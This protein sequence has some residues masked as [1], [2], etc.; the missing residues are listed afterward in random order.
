MIQKQA[1][2]L[3][4]FIAHGLDV[5]HVAR[6]RGVAPY[7]RRKEESILDGVS[8]FREFVL[9]GTKRSGYQYLGNS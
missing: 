8:F 5:D 4:L 3:R 7:R 9:H 6:L 2:M 1:E